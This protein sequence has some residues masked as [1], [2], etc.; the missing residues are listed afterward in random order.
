VVQWLGID[1]APRMGA[2]VLGCTTPGDAHGALR[3]AVVDEAFREV[4]PE[5]RVALLFDELYTPAFAEREPAVAAA[6]RSNMLATALPPLFANLHYRASQ[7]HDAWDLLPRIA[8]PTLVIH[9]GEDRVNPTANAHLLAGRIPGA[10]LHI[11]P[12]GRHGFHV[13]FRE[14]ASPVVLDFLARHPLS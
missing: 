11:V 2:L 8:N 4:G 13:E 6:I 7:G 1:H 9:G 14:E 5:R 3:P 12:N 10:E